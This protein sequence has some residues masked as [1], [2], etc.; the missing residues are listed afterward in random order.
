MF[1]ERN[2]GLPVFGFP[3]TDQHEELV[4]GKP[5]QVQWF[6]RNRLELHPENPPPYDVLL[7][8]LGVDRLQQQ[9]RDWFTFPK[10]DPSA[11]HY[12]AQT[13]HAIAP[14]FWGYWS[15]H[16]L[17]FDRH[18]GTSFAESQALFGMPL[19]EPAMET[20]SSG[21]TVLTQWFERTRFELHPENAPPYDVLLGLLGNEVAG[22]TP[23]APVPQPQPIDNQYFPLKPGT[24]FIYEGTSEGHNERDEVIVTHETKLIQGIPC[25]VVNDSVVQDGQL[26][27]K[28]IDWY[29]QDKDGNV[30]YYGEDVKEYENGVLVSTE[31]SW[32]AGVNGAQAGII[33]EAHPQVGDTYRQENAPNVAEDM[34]QVLRL[35]ESVTVPYGSYTNV[36][37]TK[38]WTPLEPDVVDNVY[39]APGVGMIQ[40]VAV[41]GPEEQ[42]KLVSIKT[43]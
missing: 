17:E 13:G 36:L 15:S 39:Y 6:E 35:T 8:R 3:T 16:G 26:I 32:E 12:F 14:Q 7:G 9:A 33:M 4:E 21:A 41:Q 24:T 38:D 43:E 2:G 40:S 31:G 20:N 42:I 27:E 29:A 30:W 37:V 25:V 28:T 34:A 18:R 23:P 5:F 11:P 19:S 10:A 22:G 1:W